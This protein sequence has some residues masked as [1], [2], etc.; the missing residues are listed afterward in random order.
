MSALCT[1]IIYEFVTDQKDRPITETALFDV[2]R[3]NK[4]EQRIRYTMH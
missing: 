4:L 1:M 2:R 3:K